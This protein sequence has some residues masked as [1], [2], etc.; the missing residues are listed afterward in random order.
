LGV[1]LVVR[2]LSFRHMVLSASAVDVP[3]IVPKDGI[4]SCTV[5]LAFSGIGAGILSLPWALST[6]GLLGGAVVLAVTA[7]LSCLSCC[8]LLAARRQCQGAEGYAGVIAAYW[9]H[10]WAVNLV[11]LLDCFGA[12]VVY[13]DYCAEAVLATAVA[14]GWPPL[15]PALV[16]AGF[17]AAAVPLSMPRSIT[18]AAS[19]SPLCLTALAY[20]C[21]LVVLQAFTGG[22]EGSAEGGSVELFTVSRSSLE[23]TCAFFFSFVSQMNIFDVMDTLSDPTPKRK[24]RVAMFATL[25]MFGAYAL[26]SSCGYV[27]FG[28]EVHADVLENFPP[29]RFD[30]VFANI[31]MVGMLLICFVLALYP[32]RKSI[33]ALWSPGEES[34]AQAWLA[35]TLLVAAAAATVAIAFPSIVSALNLFGGFFAPCI[36]FVFPALTLR[37]SEAPGR[38][39]ALYGAALVGFASVARTVLQASGIAS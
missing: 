21:A 28:S 5:T 27:A 9:P 3:A 31:A 19:F 30:V 35:S 7:S 6:W 24:Q 8:V 13:V 17:C 1:G 23:G 26:V 10:A 4:F 2:G 25:L 11:V 29:K 36:I 22:P 14:F 16:K 15:S 32:V 12:L 38:A 33:L 20:I 37:I 34:G 18:R 39:A